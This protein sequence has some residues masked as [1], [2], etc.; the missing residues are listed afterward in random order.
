M[1]KNCLPNPTWDH[2]C[3]PSKM[4]TNYRETSVSDGHLLSYHLSF[5]LP[6]NSQ[7]ELTVWAR[8]ASHCWQIVF[9]SVCAKGTFVRVFRSQCI[10]T[11]PCPEKKHPKH[12]RLSLKE[13]FTNFNNF[14]Y[15]YFWHNWPSNDWLIYHL[16]QCLLLYYLG[17]NEPTKNVLKWTN[18][19]KSIPNI[20]V[21]DL[22][23]D[24]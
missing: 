19:S 1:P 3:Y 16:T 5:S 14:W 13:M 17:K 24:W 12:Y 9:I 23:K 20:I 11:T 2:S 10:V 21:C 22:K 7:C 15:K 6:P 8:K 4:Q 18:T